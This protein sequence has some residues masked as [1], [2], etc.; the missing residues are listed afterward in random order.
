[1]E[2]L[3]LWIS[4]N[5]NLIYCSLM[6]KIVRKLIMRSLN[7]SFYFLLITAIQNN[8]YAENVSSEGF[9]LEVPYV[10]QADKFCGPAALAMVLRYWNHPINQYEIAGDYMPF[11]EDGLSGSLMKQA[12][13]DRGLHAY[14]FKG[15]RSDLVNHLRKGRL[16]I[17]ALKTPYPSPSNH[18]VVLVGWIAESKEWIVH[19]PADGPYQ[20]CAEERFE[21]RWN[22]LANWTL[23]VLPGNEK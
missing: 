14:S 20:R 5:S 16:L 12:V 1:M 23:L 13:T 7:I 22:K 11:P 3:D 4:K 8:G 2:I 9:F 10:H 15:T 19:D 21:A 17:V 6:S 18:Y